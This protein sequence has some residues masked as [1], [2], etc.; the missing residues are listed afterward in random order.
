MITAAGG[1]AEHIAARQECGD[2]MVELA[3]P[4]DRIVIMGAR[5]DTLHD[6]AQ[7]ILAG[8]ARLQSDVQA[9]G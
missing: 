6:F 1:R 2:R 9:V 5:D 4:G 8:I 3:K 7:S